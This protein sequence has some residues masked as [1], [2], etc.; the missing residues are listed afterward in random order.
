MY[1]Y[2]KEKYLEFKLEN[3]LDFFAVQIGYFL[4][5][6]EDSSELLKVFF[7]YKLH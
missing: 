2:E 5:T 1:K 7:N 4:T 6:F 3:N